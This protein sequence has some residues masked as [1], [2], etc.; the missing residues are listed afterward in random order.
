M[1][2]LSL[3]MEVIK[4]A[5]RESEGIDSAIREISIEVGDL[6]GVEADAFQSALELL[7]AESVLKGSAIKI[8]RTSGTGI[9][10]AC[11]REFEMHSFIDACPGCNA[12]PS[13]IKGGNEFR[14]ISLIV[15]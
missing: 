15:D 12:F 11:S 9:C 14:V 3:A 5:E 4:I 2:E 8:I 6:S 7:A 1:H 13:E 10:N